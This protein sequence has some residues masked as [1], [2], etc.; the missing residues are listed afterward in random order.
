M[1]RYGAQDADA[2]HTAG[3]LRDACRFAS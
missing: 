3:S 1:V 2:Y